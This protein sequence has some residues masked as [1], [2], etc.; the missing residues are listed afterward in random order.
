[1][2]SSVSRVM[3]SA[4]AISASGPCRSHLSTSRLATRS[5]ASK[6][7]F[8]ARWLKAGIR[9]RCALPQLASS[10]CAVNRPSPAMPR[11]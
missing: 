2:V 6:Y 8:I 3:S 11:R 5:I 4:T 7:P 9:M 10:V 1:M